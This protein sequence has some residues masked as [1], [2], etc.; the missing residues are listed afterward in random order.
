MHTSIGNRE[1]E[2][3]R[4]QG[5]TACPQ[6]RPRPAHLAHGR[7][8][9]ALA[10]VQVP[11]GE[12]EEP[13]LE[14]CVVPAVSTSPVSVASSSPSADPRL[15]KTRKLSNGT[16]APTTRTGSAALCGPPTA[17]RT[18]RCR[19]VQAGPCCL[20]VGAANSAELRFYKRWRGECCATRCWCCSGSRTLS[21]SPPCS[22]RPRGCTG[23]AY[24]RACL[25]AR[26][27]TARVRF[28]L[29]VVR[30]YAPPCTRH[31]RVARIV[32]ARSVRACTGQRPRADP[33]GGWACE[34][35]RS[36]RLMAARTRRS[37]RRGVARPARGGRDGGL[38]ACGLRAMLCA[39]ACAVLD[40]VPHNLSR[41]PDVPLVPMVCVCECAPQGCKLCACVCVQMR[42]YM[43]SCVILYACVCFKFMCTHIDV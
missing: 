18:Q 33:E 21:L 6:T 28:V 14:P 40:P 10:G 7:S 9:D 20:I 24:T 41:R 37:R 1:R 27:Q 35:Q 31:L 12:P 4:A 26:V 39:A 8:H 42:M 23:Y 22:C 17:S 36:G 15:C 19:G 16:R 11:G 25:R 43:Y 32:V 29:A 3:G 38:A 5:V 30:L 34:R 2:R 13:V